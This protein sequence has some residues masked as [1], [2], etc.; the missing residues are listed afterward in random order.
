[1]LQRFAH[2]VRKSGRTRFQADALPRGG[3]LEVPD[4]KVSGSLGICVADECGVSNLIAD[5]HV[6]HSPGHEYQIA[7]RRHDKHVRRKISPM[8]QPRE[9]EHMLRCTQQY[10]IETAGR[11]FLSGRCQATVQLVIRK[12]I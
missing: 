12:G 5:D 7:I 9:I 10:Q 11:H 2:C 6:L 4:D 3:S 8:V 1:M